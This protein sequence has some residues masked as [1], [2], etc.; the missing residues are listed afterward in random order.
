VPL[1]NFSNLLLSKVKFIRNP[2]GVNKTSGTSLPNSSII[3]ANQISGANFGFRPL[4]GGLQRI[5]LGY[6]ALLQTHLIL[7]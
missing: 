1:L 2:I 4:K 6:F 7:V 5:N 3:L